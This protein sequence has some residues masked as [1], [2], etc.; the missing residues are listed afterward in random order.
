[1]ELGDWY[2][3]RDGNWQYDE[4][5]PTPSTEATQ[6]RPRTRAVLDAIHGDAPTP[7]D[8][9]RAGDIGDWIDPNAPD[10]TPPEVTDP[11]DP[12]YVHPWFGDR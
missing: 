7:P 4:G 1:V 2:Q 9:P 11:Q 12:S 6:I 8:V 10:P 5:A 3:D